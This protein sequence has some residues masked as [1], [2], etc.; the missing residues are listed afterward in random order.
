M[1]GLLLGIDLLVVSLDGVVM[2]SR[3]I[4]IPVV[5]SV[6]SIRMGLSFTCSSMKSKCFVLP[7]MVLNAMLC[8]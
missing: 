4:V 5:A 6:V 8:R 7:I 2:L 1:V 3:L